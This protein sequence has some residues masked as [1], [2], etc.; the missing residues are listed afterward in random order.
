MSEIKITGKLGQI[1]RR[2]AEKAFF[3][4]F[5]MRIRQKADLFIAFCTRQLI[6]L[7]TAGKVEKNKVIFMHYND[8]YQC[9]PAYICDEILR[10][11][12]DY[13]IVYVAGKKQMAE[14]P[15]PFPEGVRVVRRNSLENF[16]E[17]ATAKVW[18][19]NAVCFPWAYV[20]KK[21]DQI[22]IN[23]WHGSMGLK[24]IDPSSISDPKWRRAANIAG[25]ITNFMISNSSFETEVYRTTY[26][27]DPK[28]KVLEFGHPRNDILFCDEEKKAGIRQ[29]VMDFFDIGEDC[30]LILYAPTFRDAR[31]LDVYDID[32]RRIL[33]A[34]EKRFGGK[35]KI[36]NRYHHKVAGKLASVKAV[37]NDPDI[38]PGNLYP[39]IQELMVAADLGITDYSSWICDYVLTGKPGFIYANDLKAYDGERGFYY[40][41]D[42]TPFPIAEN[43]DEMEKNILNFDEEKYSAGV[44]DFLKARGS[45][46][47]G[48]AA[49]RVVALIKRF[50]TETK[51]LK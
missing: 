4:F 37:R 19:D 3:K 28:V 2:A 45:K 5:F 40:P 18:V 14:F 30:G 16:Y 15:L 36:I 31:N 23:T 11:G 27:P 22:Y 41:L 8:C 47:D 44:K 17:A 24:K 12:L 43:N 34:A 39:D 29:K 7:K 13:D 33:S 35:W 38:L 48:K 50:M 46:E 1:E 49:K 10:Q 21:K 20:P 32:Y 26:W 51:D 9:N 25:N 6:S 42:S